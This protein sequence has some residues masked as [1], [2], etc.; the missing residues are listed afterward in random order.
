MDQHSSALFRLPREIRD[1]IY[2]YYVW[3][4]KCS[5][6]YCDVCASESLISLNLGY[7]H[8]PVTD[9]LQTFDG[10]VIRNALSYT[11]KR[12]AQEM[13]GLALR[14][15]TVTFRTHLS[16]PREIDMPS[17]AALFEDLMGQR[18]RTLRRMLGFVPTLVSSEILQALCDQWPDCKAIEKLKTELDEDGPSRLNDDTLSL[19]RYDH[20]IDQEKEQSITED[21]VQLLVGHPD[22]DSLTSDGYTKSH[23][24]RWQQDMGYSD[25]QMNAVW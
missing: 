13:D 16:L 24:E 3:E 20:G 5:R 1:E 12:V 6:W 14:F 10:R 7:L 25:E 9:R 21:L 8:N 17:D 22:F 2:N 23:W 18:H 11:C 15:N 4:E 19:H